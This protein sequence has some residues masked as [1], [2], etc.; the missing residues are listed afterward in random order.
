MVA[1]C[2]AVDRARDGPRQW[3]RRRTPAAVAQHDH[4]VRPL[5][6]GVEA[7]QRHPEAGEQAVG[8]RRRRAAPGRG[9][10]DASRASPRSGRAA[11]RP[12]RPRPPAAAATSTSLRPWARAHATDC[13][14]TSTPLSGN[15][16][17]GRYCVASATSSSSASSVDRDAAQLREAVA[18]RDEHGAHR[19]RVHRLDRDLGE[20]PGERG[21]GLEAGLVLL[22]GRRA[23]AG[24]LAAGER[25][26][27]RLG[28]V[29]ARRAR[30]SWWISSKKTMTDGWRTSTRRSPRS[31][32]SALDRRGERQQ[33]HVEHPDLAQRL[34]APSRRRSAARGPRRSRSCP[35]RPGPSRSGLRFVRRSRTS[36]IASSSRSRPTI[37]PE[38][39]VPGEADESRPNR[40]SVGVDDA[41]AAQVDGRRD[42]FVACRRVILPRRRSRGRSPARGGRSPCPG[43]GRSRSSGRRS[44]AGRRAP[45]RRRSRRGSWRARRGR[46]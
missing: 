39:A 1:V 14:M 36:T 23:D 18:D 24:D 13:S 9:V 6:A 41:R 46:S 44:R 32:G 16:R 27:E 35:S 21:L 45:R 15:E 33:R 8:G 26:L 29:P 19:R 4:G 42:R 28:E 43:T 30:S 22:R 10:V 37:G 2:P 38:L 11:S 12:S 34:R 31:L 40:S 20:A 17:F 3:C 7:A 5:G 25:R